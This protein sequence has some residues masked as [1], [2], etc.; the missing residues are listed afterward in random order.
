MTDKLAQKK[1][2]CAGICVCP[3]FCIYTPFPIFSP[4]GAERHGI[5]VETTQPKSPGCESFQVSSS[6]PPL[7]GTCSKTPSWYL[8]PQQTK[9]YV[10]CF[11]V[12]FFSLSV[13]AYDNIKFTI[14]HSKKVTAADKKIE[15]LKQYTI[16]KVKCM[17]S[18]SLSLPPSLL[19]S[20][21]RSENGIGYCG[22]NG[23]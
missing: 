16:I 11:W 21:I 18:L 7:R 17:W 14:R 20:E 19:L 3:I 13:H 15:Q 12:F 23:R 1:R 5:K 4:S 10:Y 2:V 6:P 9:P 22:M 8:K